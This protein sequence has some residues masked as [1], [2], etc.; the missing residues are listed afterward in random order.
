MLHERRP[1]T[2][3]GAQ[4]DVIAV[5]N[6]TLVVAYN[7]SPNKRSPLRLATSADGGLTWA[8]AAVIENDPEGSFHYPA[9]LYDA[10]KVRHMVA[11]AH[12]VPEV[13]D[14]PAI[15]VNSALSEPRFKLCAS[16]SI[17]SLDIKV[18]HDCPPHLCLITP[19]TLDPL[20]C[21]C[22]LLLQ[23]RRTPSKPSRLAGI[24]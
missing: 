19:I 18:S 21:A 14:L 9:L 12:S 7:D 4:M 1:E 20:Q 3:R 17:V 13:P 23:G 22:L 15:A 6:N 16:L 24:N 5:P 2:Q 8:K 11:S 10:K